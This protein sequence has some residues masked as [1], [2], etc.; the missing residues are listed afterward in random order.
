MSPFTRETKISWREQVLIKYFIWLAILVVLIIVGGGWWQI[1]PIYSEWRTMTRAQDL[2]KSLVEIKAQVAAL[3]NKV[4]AWNKIKKQ[5]GA[6][7]HLILPSNIDI[8]DLLTQIEDLV[9]KNKYI[10]NSISISESGTT[11]KKIEKNTSDTAAS[12]V[13]S[14]KI[15]LALSGQGYENFKT[16]L[17]A[18]QSAWRMLNVNSF[19]YSESTDSYNIELTSYYY[20]R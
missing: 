6:D 4:S 13:R 8:P 3:D 20:P 2:Q 1:K 12:G 15:T 18:L 10:L 7:L 5:P 9:N 16:M 14:V 19:N 11:I 17:Q